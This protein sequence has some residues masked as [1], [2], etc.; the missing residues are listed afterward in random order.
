MNTSKIALYTNSE[1][2]RVLP[3]SDAIICMFEHTDEN[4]S[5]YIPEWPQW[6]H[7]GKPSAD[8]ERFYCCAMNWDAMDLKNALQSYESLYAG[9]KQ[10]AEKLAEI[11]SDSAEDVLSEDLQKVWNKYLRD[12]ETDAFDMALI[13]DLS[14]RLFLGV[15]VSEE[16]AVAYAEYKA[17]VAAESK[18]RVG[19][20]P[21]SCDVILRAKRLFKLM[22]LDAPRIIVACEA[23]Y[24]AQ[25][26]VIHTYCREMKTVENVE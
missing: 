7:Y 19:D 8:K 10:I 14:E 16:E 3:P 17:A 4:G 13:S 5:L 25:A 22:T 1:D 23:N 24:L 15:S 20:S 11:C 18:A 2:G 21:A 26:M 12:Y 9:L 6:P